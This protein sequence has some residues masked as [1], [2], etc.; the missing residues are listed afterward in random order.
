MK[1]DEIMRQAAQERHEMYE[2]CL[3]DIS[4]CYRVEFSDGG[5]RYYHFKCKLCGEDICVSCLFDI[6]DENG[7]VLAV[8]GANPILGF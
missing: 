2:L 5:Y 4:K 6:T 8:L 7:D 3:G 1:I